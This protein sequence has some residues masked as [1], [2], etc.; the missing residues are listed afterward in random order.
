MFPN[1]G[2]KRGQASPK[3]NA[4]YD[5]VSDPRATAAARASYW[6]RKKDRE[7]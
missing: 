4:V 3:T 6:R 2:N 1:N 5:N 7:T